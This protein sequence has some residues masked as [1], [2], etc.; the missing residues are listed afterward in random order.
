MVKSVVLNSAF[1]S[2][3]NSGVIKSGSGGMSVANDFIEEW[4][5]DYGKEWCYL[6]G[7]EFGG[8]CGKNGM[9][10]VVVN[11]VVV[12][13]CMVSGTGKTKLLPRLGRSGP[14]LSM[15]Q[16]INQQTRDFLLK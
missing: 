4:C 7:E 10:S 15:P 16:I 8:E 1:I 2:E 13:C 12:K 9:N 5:G 11:S 14:S 3:V 6:F